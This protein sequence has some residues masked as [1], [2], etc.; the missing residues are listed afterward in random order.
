MMMKLFRFLIVLCLLFPRQAAFGQHAADSL[1]QF[2]QNSTQDSASAKALNELSEVLWRNADYNAAQLMAQQAFNICEKNIKVRNPGKRAYLKEK[3]NACNHFAII[4]RFLGN[5]SKSLEDHFTALNIRQE[6]G[7]QKGIARSYLGIG[8]IY[9]FLGNMKEALSYKLKAKKLYEDAGDS[10]GM[11]NTCSHIG[12]IYVNLG[13][14]NEALKYYSIALTTFTKKKDLVGMGDTYGYIGKIYEKKG[15]YEQAI[16]NY[17]FSLKIN[18]DYG[19]KDGII[20]GNIFLGSAY[21]QLKKYEKARQCYDNALIIA[22]QIRSKIH[23]A[24]IYLGLAQVDSA[25]GNSTAAFEHYK[26]HIIYRDSLVN[27]KTVETVAN[28]KSRIESEKKEQIRKL[29]ETQREIKQQEKEQ[30]QKIILYSVC[31]GLCMALALAIV[32]YRGSRQKQ[33][34][35]VQLLA[36]NEEINRQ[37][38]LVEN[39]NKEITDSITY[40]RRIQSSLLPTEKYIDKNLKRLKKE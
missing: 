31:M 24:D 27:Q 26:T 1:R 35:N 16:E 28:L 18:T 6:I 37:K 2:I 38:H 19:S 17:N 29:K 15:D 39:K 34:A 21:K 9:L 25:L 36:Q 40:A 30:Q 23:Q 7:D 32:I 4:N 12:E 14:N 10:I 13:N 8:S 33:K 5:Y 20:E 3:A 11:A 22:K